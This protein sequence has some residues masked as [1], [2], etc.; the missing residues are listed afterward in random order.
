VARDFFR[1][2]RVNL[3]LVSPLRSARHLRRW[4][5]I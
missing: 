2:E 3:A 4:L 1:P 5:W